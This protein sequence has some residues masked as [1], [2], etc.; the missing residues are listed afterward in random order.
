MQTHQLENVA[1][2]TQQ[3]RV[4]RRGFDTS[5]VQKEDA[6]GIW[7]VQVT[8]APRPGLAQIENLRYELGEPSPGKTKALPCPGDQRVCVRA[9]REPRGPQIFGVRGQ[10]TCDP[11]LA[12]R[13]A[14]FGPNQSAVA[15]PLCRRT[16]PKSFGCG[17]RRTAYSGIRC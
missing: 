9:I 11:A 1:F 2:M 7:R 12:S 3:V 6:N 8:P 16:A 13:G 15:A 4:P 5:L 10:T 14:V 17:D